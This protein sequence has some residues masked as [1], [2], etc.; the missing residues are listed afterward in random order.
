MIT[1]GGDV[2]P[3][4]YGQPEHRSVYGV[5]T[6][7]DLR[8]LALLGAARDLGMP[9]MGICRG[10]QII[11]VEAGGSLVQNVPDVVGHDDHAWSM[12]PVR[13]VPGSQVHRTLGER[14]I[15][16]HLHHQ[17]V[18]KVA[19]GFTVT[20]R[21]IDGTIEAIESV[22]GRVVG[23]QFHPESVLSTG[24]GTHNGW[25]IF[26]SF[27]ATCTRYRRRIERQGRTMLPYP[28]K[29]VMAWPVAVQAHKTWWTSPV[30]SSTT[31][32]GSGA[33]PKGSSSGNAAT[34]SSGKSGTLVLVKD[35]N[36]V[37]SLPPIVEWCGPCGVPF[38]DVDDYVAH[39][40]W[41]HMNQLS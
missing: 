4:I 36:G 19:K 32:K 31:Y 12:M 30:S 25:M 22:D 26:D 38:E 27:V 16:L 37:T 6:S 1:G 28:E 7:R 15:M 29:Y 10:L 5:S 20:A 34:T 3:E 8:E 18:R 13:T 33:S 41:F 39:M 14:P 11:N 23:V 9:V 35:K 21:H 40:E 17:A 2:N 24:D